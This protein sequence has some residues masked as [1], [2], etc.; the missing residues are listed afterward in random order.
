MVI[1]SFGVL[2]T[3]MKLNDYR[4]AIEKSTNSHFIPRV[5]FSLNMTDE[6]FLLKKR[7]YFSSSLYILN[8]MGKVISLFS[9]PIH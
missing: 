9:K 1:G 2:E 4:M 3:E 7:Y 8:K 6:L 5:D